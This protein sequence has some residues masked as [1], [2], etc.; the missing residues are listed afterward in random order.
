MLILSGSAVLF[1]W[2]EEINY[3]VLIFVILTIVFYLAFGIAAG[4]KSKK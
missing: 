1:K 3:F 4:I 2:S